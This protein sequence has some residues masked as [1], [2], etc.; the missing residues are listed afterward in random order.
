MKEYECSRKYAIYRVRRPERKICS[1]SL[2]MSFSGIRMISAQIPRLNNP[3]TSFERI[4]VR[5]TCIYSFLTRQFSFE[6]E[7]VA[8]ANALGQIC[9]HTTRGRPNHVLASSHIKQAFVFFKHAQ[10]NKCIKLYKIKSVES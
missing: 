8:L 9:L 7:C 10:A 5:H 6:V 3:D 1:H 2:G 4:R